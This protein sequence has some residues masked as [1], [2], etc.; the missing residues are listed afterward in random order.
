MT[1]SDF[2]HTIDV[3]I[4]GLEA[5]D[6]ETLIIQPGPGRWS[7]GQVYMHILDEADFQLEQITACLSSNAH[8]DGE[9]SREAKKMFEKNSFPNLLIEGPPSN[10]FV[11]QPESKEHIM[12]RLLE[13]EQ[14]VDAVDARISASPV[15]GKAMHPG[16]HYLSARE[17]FQ[18][19]EM[20]FRHHLRQKARL[21]AFLAGLKA[22]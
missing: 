22:R 13:L 18:F 19:S 21:D 1:A 14:R 15:Q 5:Y 6:F 10:A 12:Q 7:V 3:W 9:A 17:W 4:N 20:H 11:Q 8:A 2:R 16:L